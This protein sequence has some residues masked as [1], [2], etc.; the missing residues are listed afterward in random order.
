MLQFQLILY[1]YSGIG[2][3]PVQR[4]FIA[5]PMKTPENPHTLLL[6]DNDSSSRLLV[7][8][9]MSDTGIRIIATGCGKEALRLLR[10]HSKN[11]ILVITELRLPHYD[12]F[13]LLKEFRSVN[14]YVPV[15]AL[16]AMP[17]G[18][19]EQCC[20]QA[21]F[22]EIIYKPFEITEFKRKVMSYLPSYPQRRHRP[23]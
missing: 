2:S 17:P 8:E 7:S 16:T 12:G 10:D 22:D 1:F 19:V 15:I 18:L 13:S 9:I 20:S 5:A 11:L 23:V 4:I 6:I 3:V 14:R 21:G